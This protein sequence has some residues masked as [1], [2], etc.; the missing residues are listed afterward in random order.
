MRRS[1]N[2]DE[3]RPRTSSTT[4]PIIT[5]RKRSLSLPAS[6]P[7][8]HLP[9]ATPGRLAPAPRISFQLLARG[10]GRAG[11]RRGEEE[12]R[13]QCHPEQG[14]NLP[15]LALATSARVVPGVASPGQPNSAGQAPGGSRGGCLLPGTRESRTGWPD[16]GAEIQRRRGS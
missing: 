6:P 7:H 11:G 2:G 4:T 5:S 8:F 16:P 12:G 13:R 3:Y 14:V 9:S 10:T 1:R 15:P